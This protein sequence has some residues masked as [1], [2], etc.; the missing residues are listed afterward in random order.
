[1]SNIRWIVSRA[2]KVKGLLLLASLLMTLESLS[3]LAQVGLQQTMIDDVLIEGRADRFWP[4]LLLIA[5]SYAMYALLFTFGPHTLHHSVARVRRR[6]AQELMN[7]LHRIPIGVLQKERTASYVYHFSNDLQTAATMAGGEL[8]R[9]FQQG[10]N[11]IVLVF[12]IYAASPALLLAV[13]AAALLYVALGKTFAAGRKQAASEVNRTRSA[14]LVHMEEGVS[15]TRE[16]VAFHRQAW[17]AANYYKLYG[18]YY[19]SV[20]REGKLVNKQSLVSDPLRWGAVLLVLLYGGILVLDGALSLGMFVITFQ[21]TSRFIDSFHGLYQY[22]L[23]LSGKMASVERLRGFLEG[24]AIGTEGRRLDGPVAS[25]RFDRVTFAYGDDREPVLRGIDLDIPVGRKVAFVGTSGGGKSTIAGLLVRYFEPD[26]GR[27]LVNGAPIADWARDEWMK[28]VAI[29]FQEPYLLPDTIR[30]NLLLGLDGVPEEKLTETCKAMHIHDFIAGLPEGYD[31]VIGERG[32][33]L[34]GGQRQRLALARALLRD[35][36]LLLLDEA[37]SSLDLETERLVQERLDR[38][39]EGR[40][41][42]TIAH[43]LSTVRNADVI[44]VLDRGRLAESG[45]HDELLQAG[46]VYRELV[47]KERSGNGDGSRDEAMEEAADMPPPDKYGKRGDR[48][49][50]RIER[51]R[52]RD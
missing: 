27:L 5:A 28:R 26:S 30:T 34:S 2:G 47:W 50:V 10:T 37:T 22:A 16:V 12:V 31:T 44:F 39:R 23:G 18:N 8:P 1:M 45:S 19:A 42:I 9:L 36:E 41:T 24:E 51:G 35:P 46:G 38:L 25:I 52:D 49:D 20:M 11:V 4:T 29:V 33:T 13:A 3:Y 14:L 6:L 48:H 43:R 32:V 17:E 21:F 7:R 40:T 15:S